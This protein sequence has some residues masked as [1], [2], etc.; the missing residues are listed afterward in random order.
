MLRASWRRRDWPPANWFLG[1]A[2]V[3][4][5]TNFVVPPSSAAARVVTVHDLTPVKFRD[6][7]DPMSLDFREFVQRAVRGGASIHTH[8]S[9]V[10]EEVIDT[11]G[12][13][14]SRVTAIWP[15]LPDLD[16]GHGQAG[17][18]GDS[19]PQGRYILAIGTIEP[20]KDFPTL[21]AAFDQLAHDRPD[22]TLVIIGAD[23]WGTPAL[24]DAI[25]SARHADRITRL[26]Y[27][28][29]ADVLSWLGSS[30]A[31]AYPSRYEGF[32][33]PPLLAMSMGIPVVATA[34]GAIPEV[35]GTAAS[36]V[37][38]GDVDA[39][40][41]ALAAVL[42]DDGLAFRLRQAGVARA[43]CFSWSGC[44]TAM[45]ALYEAAVQQACSR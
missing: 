26:G 27:L 8:S 40:G 31:L 20:R 25:S 1:T 36:L 23:G 38:V 21:V 22:V 3:I 37:P 45:V 28:A 18:R 7:C 43:R 6:F 34:A 9:F 42:D 12:A 4:H 13:D 15:G 29:E 16:G 24:D 11:F 5:G 17:G 2:D 19:R 30:A 10:A 14:P 32:G 41:A 33:F 39:L 44:A 35:T